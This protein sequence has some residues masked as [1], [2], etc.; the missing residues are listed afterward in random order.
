MSTD[1]VSV[2]MPAYNAE[3]YIADSITS[4]LAQTYSN[5]ELIVVDDGSTDSTATVVQ[6][7]VRRDRR[8]KYLFQENGRLGKARNTGIGNSTG[9]L[10]A[11]LDSDDLWMPTKLKAQTRAIAENNADVVYSKSY[12]FSDEN[13]DDETEILVSSVG[14]FSGPDFFDS[15]VRQP[16][17]PVLTVLLKR[18]ALDRVG[19]FEEGK[20]YHGCEDSDLWLR[21]ARAGLVFYGMPDVL[22]RYRRH[23]TAMTALPS[24]MFKLTLLIVRRYIDQSGLSEL[25]KQRRLTGLY[26]E[27]I[28]ALLNEG[29]ISEAKQFVH[30][31][32][33]WNK[34]SIVTRVQKI[35]I[36]IW[37]QQFNFISRECLYR[38]E[39][40]LQNSFGRGKPH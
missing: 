37:P 8:I 24:N 4:V 23:E 1:L 28:A 2:I 12:V 20:A 19:L 30:E 11:F 33:L 6:E 14:K 31:M 36:S 22:A 10:V 40:H 7:F 21:M 38:T 9:S 26:R 16:Q 18:S 27:L 29:K 17:I 35:L 39:W 5:W 3:R 15:L 34:N 32:Y 25:E 13:T